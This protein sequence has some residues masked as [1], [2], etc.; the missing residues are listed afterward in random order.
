MIKNYWSNE[1]IRFLV[2]GLVNS[3]FGWIVFLVSQLLITGELS[4]IISLILAYGLGTL[5]SFLLQKYFVFRAH[6]NKIREFLR[7]AVIYIP[8][9]IINIL[10][11]P[12]IVA[13]LGINW[14]FAQTIFICLAAVLSYFGHKYFSFNSK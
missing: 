5:T 14:L 13:I 12:L 4:Y 3:F 6:G 8:Q 1:K 10:L 7:Y 9:L 11:L 2:L